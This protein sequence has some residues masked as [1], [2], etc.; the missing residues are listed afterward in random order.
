MNNQVIALSKSDISDI[1]ALMNELNIN[2]KPSVSNV[3]VSNVIKIQSWIRM[4]LVNKKPLIPS[5]RYQTK[6]WRKSRK[7]YSTGKSNECEIYQIKMIER[8][9][10]LKIIKTFDRIHMKTL[11]I[12]EKKNPLKDIDG[13]EY[14]ENFD[15]V[16]HINNKKVYYNLK[17]V[18]DAGGA[19]TR[20]LRE[21]YHFLK[22]QLKV[23]LLSNDNT[24][25]INILD[26]DTSYKS[27]NKYKYL[28]DSPEYVK[29]KKN[30]FIGDLA[31]F[32]SYWSS[33]I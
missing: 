33:S 29:V 5:S 19:Q 16:H 10:K 12:V 15:G 3:L 21:V 9:T 20:S 8:I 1:N 31:M 13:F 11:T 2:D 7:W 32:Q 28:I 24:F 23:L 14:T 26:G 6:A 30:I 18:C 27:M 17:F 22:C 4:K 25:F